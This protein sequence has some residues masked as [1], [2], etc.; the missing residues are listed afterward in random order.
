MILELN[1]EPAPLGKYSYQRNKE[2]R[3]ILKPSGA[4]FMAGLEWY[5]TKAVTYKYGQPT[6]SWFQLSWKSGRGSRQNGKWFK[7]KFFSDSQYHNYNRYRMKCSLE[8]V[9]GCSPWT[10]CPSQ[11]ANSWYA[12]QSEKPRGSQPACLISPVP[13]LFTVVIAAVRG[14]CQI[15]V[16]RLTLKLEFYKTWW[17]VV[18]RSGLFVVRLK[19]P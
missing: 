4:R 1:I 5:W 16:D 19:K 9:G 2:R 11:W 15:P 12:L 7:L 17:W 8:T 3:V 18:S 14:V 10:K 13:K 6:S